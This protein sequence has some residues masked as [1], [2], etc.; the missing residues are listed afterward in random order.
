M[1]EREMRGLATR[2]AALSDVLNFPTALEL[3]KSNPDKAEELLLEREASLQR[4]A[5]FADVRRRL[6]AS[7][8]R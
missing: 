5:E 6:Q 4:Q 2:L 7:L 8:R 3:A 1:R